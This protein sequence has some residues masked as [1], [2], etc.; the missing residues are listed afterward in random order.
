MTAHDLPQL[1]DL[2]WQV[3]LKLLAEQLLLSCPAYRGAASL[4][5][6]VPGEITRA[7]MAFAKPI[8]LYMTVR[9]RTLG[10][11][12]GIRNRLLAKS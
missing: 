7:K 11:K 5:L 10:C 3:S 1:C 9:T 4:P 12:V 6:Y 2:L 8:V